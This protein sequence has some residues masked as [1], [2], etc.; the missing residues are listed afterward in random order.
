[1]P[2]NQKSIFF[3]NFAW[4]MSHYFKINIRSI[5]D[6]ISRNPKRALAT[7]I[8]GCIFIRYSYIN[9]RNWKNGNQRVVD[10]GKDKKVED[11]LV[12]DRRKKM[13]AVEE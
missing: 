1:M 13:A 9:F 12:K 3:E 8:F 10:A 4:Y 6:Y 2:L 11:E 7:S 5:S